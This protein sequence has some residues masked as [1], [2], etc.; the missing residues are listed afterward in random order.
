MNNKIKSIFQLFL[1]VVLGSLVGLLI[2]NYIDYNTLIKPPLAP[3]KLLFP[4]AWTI[5]YLLM[6]I[7]YYLYKKDIQEETETTKKITIIYYLQLFINLLWSIIFFILKNRL[8]AS[9]W[10]I[11]L[12]LLVIYLIYLFFKEKKISA[13][14]NIPYLLWI[15]FATYLTIGI[16]LLN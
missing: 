13:Y 2:S 9:L 8:L 6:G 15:L 11:I 16:Y 4:I 12:D 7:S 1:P 5:I 3:P 10:I 14:L